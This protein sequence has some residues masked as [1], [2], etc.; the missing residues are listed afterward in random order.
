[1][2]QLSIAMAG[3]TAVSRQSKERIRRTRR[4]RVRAGL[5]RAGVAPEMADRWCEL[6]ETEAA[7]QGMARDGDYFWDAGKGWIDAQRMSTLPSG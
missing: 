4:A 1:L 7:K 3:G 2:P 5:M 6:W